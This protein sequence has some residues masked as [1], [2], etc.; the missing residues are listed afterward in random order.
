MS[1]NQWDYREPAEPT[2]VVASNSA[3][4]GL[5]PLPDHWTPTIIQAGALF[6]AIFQVT[7]LLFDLPTAPR[8]AIWLHGA[9][10]VVAIIGF[11]SSLFPFG[12][13]HGRTITFAGLCG[14]MA[15][16]TAIAILTGNNDW[17]YAST[18]F[19][20]MGASALMPW[21]ISWQTALNLTAFASVLVQSHFVND[22]SSILH[23]V[24]VALAL[25]ISQTA[26]MIGQGYRRQV[27]EARIDAFAASKAKSEFLSS[28]SHEIRTP[29]N[30]VLGMADLLLETET[31]MEQR[32]YLNVMVANG[33][34]LLEL[35]NGILDL[36][37]IESGR[38]QIEKSEFDLTD[39]IDNTISTFWRRRAYQGPR[40]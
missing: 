39:L 19:L 6:V 22:Q 37:R 16:M 12:R 35:I 40:S 32:R 11:V 14:L 36:A 29:M 38:L 21:E 18:A 5:R 34:S 15:N 31:S 10:L 28:M 17:F 8:A 26:T 33:N 24:I 25:G 2:S 30:A 3:A 4:E 7:Y 13:V 1:A 23:W 20:T 27:E 9:N